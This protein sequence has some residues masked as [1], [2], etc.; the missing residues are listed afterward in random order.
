M[1]KTSDGLAPFTADLHIHSA[2]SGCANDNMIP[3]KIVE[4]IDELGIRVFSI[5]D[6]NAGFNCRSFSNAAKTRDILFIPGIELQTSEEIHLLGYFPDIERL[7][8]FCEDI[9]RPSLMK[10][11]KNKPQIFG[12]QIKFNSQGKAIGEDDSMLSMPLSQT[13]DELVSH[14][15]DFNGIA[16]ASHLDRD[17]SIISHLGFMPEGL[18]LDAVE[19]KEANKI[20]DIRSKHLTG[21]D[22]NVISSSDCH[23]IDLLKEA[24]M[25]LWLKD[26]DVK[27]CLD[28]IKGDGPGKIRIKTKASDKKKPRDPV[29]AEN[30]DTS[31][32][33]WKSLYG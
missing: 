26:L 14:I 8:A 3:G 22:L 23:D 2:L 33:D 21:M 16:V 29:H 31:R 12:N 13:I 25:T 27:D 11:I 28:C 32:K 19:V 6:H 30:K 15:H 7:E 20:D 24:K 4:R 10:G 17:F 1:S 5:T 18:E 9:V